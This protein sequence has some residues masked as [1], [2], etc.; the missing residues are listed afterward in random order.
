MNTQ[1]HSNRSIVKHD[2]AEV[3]KQGFCNG[4]GDMENLDSGTL[5]NGKDLNE[6]IAFNDSVIVNEDNQN[7]GSVNKSLVDRPIDGKLKD[8]EY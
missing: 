7:Q 6:S 4:S 2:Y 8:D 5:D 1:Q 3:D